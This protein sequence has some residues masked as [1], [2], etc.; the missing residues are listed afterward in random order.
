MPDSGP[1]DLNTYQQKKTL[2]EGMMDLAL[3]SANAN[4]LRYIIDQESKTSHKY[5]IVSLTSIISSLV[6]Q[7]IVAIG[8]IW[9]SSYDVKKEDQVSRANKVNN[10]TLM[11]VF[12]ITIINMFISAFG[13]PT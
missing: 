12:L 8:L 3:F 1:P 11:G 10:W 2:A 5:Y 9:N 7:I 13:I 4:Q 6:L